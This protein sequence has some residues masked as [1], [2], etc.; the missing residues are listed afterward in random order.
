MAVLDIEK[1]VES[2]VRVFKYEVP[3]RLDLSMEYMKYRLGI[4]A[5]A[6]SGMHWPLTKKLPKSK[7]G[8]VKD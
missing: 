6:M 3:K 1:R 8:T 5:S 2:L 7:S 4:W